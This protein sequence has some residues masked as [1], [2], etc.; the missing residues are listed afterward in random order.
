MAVPPPA[1]PVEQVAYDR[2]WFLDVFRR[3]LTGWHQVLLSTS[4]SGVV[5][6]AP[7]GIRIDRA[8][9]R[10]RFE[11][12]GVTRM[13]PAFA[14][15]AAQA[16]NGEEIQLLDGKTIRPKEILHQI[17][18]RAFDPEHPDFW[19]YAPSDRANPRQ[20]ESSI[21]AWSLWLSRSWLIPLLS[22]K[23]VAHIQKW[24]ASCT[25]YT[26]HFNNWS[27]FTA[28]N[29][30]VRVA[31]E[32]HGFKGD[33]EAIRRDLIVGDEVGIADGWLWDKK[34][35][36]ID[37]YNFL[38]WGSH[39]C[40]LKAILPGM[41]EKE[42]KEITLHRAIHRFERRLRHL[43]YFIDSK[44][45]NILFG[46][47]LSYRWGWLNG[48]MAAYYVGIKMPPYGLGRAMLGK[49]IQSWLNQGVL[50]EVGVLRERLSPEGSEGGRDTY[51][52]C[53]HP[54]WGMQSFL[55]LAFPAE[56][57][58]WTAPQ[59]HVP[60]HVGDYQIPAQGPGFV[61]QG[62]KSS[63]EVRLFN[64]RNLN[65]PS[66]AMYHKLV[67]SSAFPA[68]C[69][70]GKHRT[71]WDNQL[72]VRKA[73]G[74][75]IDCSEVLELDVEGSTGLWLVW[76]F[77][78]EA[79][80]EATVRTTIQL[81]GESYQTEH[82]IDVK[83]TIPLGASWVE[84]GFSLG[85]SG[86]QLEGKLSENEGWS[87]LAGQKIIFSKKLGGWK[88]LRQFNSLEK[89]WLTSIEP[90]PNIIFGHST[91]FYLT[92]PVEAGNVRLSSEHAA[93]LNPTSLKK[94]LGINS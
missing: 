49:N 59:E 58:F 72:G 77:R 84:G 20:V 52:N 26:D 43:G 57:E 75:S 5:W 73:D 17:F 91:H 12:D 42:N 32:Q 82:R 76:K 28:V 86:L 11:F 68:N 71:L 56:H 50:N 92:V 6:Q 14:A 44:G 27:L 47:S 36:G 30:A 60:V 45:R 69:D 39:H 7:G 3:L 78:F 24:L 13:V 15:W 55:C 33:R 66:N 89:G 67:Y 41:A 81:K 18:T 16:Q 22:Q 35:H 38:V 34:Y 53:G 87:E 37:Y 85:H 46:R 29:N 31:L 54:Y 40:Y 80:G 48:L 63:G 8:V 88:E 4:S 61:F 62:F 10:S 90:K 21:I 65:Y 1:I 23:E 51:I 74:N 83:G 70:S 19:E 93:S 2:S 25:T 94:S 64:L 9:S 79:D